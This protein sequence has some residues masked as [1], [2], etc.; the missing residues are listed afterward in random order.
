MFRYASGR[1]EF[2]V[3]K[4]PWPFPSSTHA[5]TICPF[6]F[7]ESGMWDDECLQKHE[8]HHWIAQIQTLVIPWLVAYIVLLLIYGGARKHPME[9]NAYKVEDDCVESLPKPAPKS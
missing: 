2:R 6:V 7:Y 1:L 3:R 4:I 5:L 8:R 9:K